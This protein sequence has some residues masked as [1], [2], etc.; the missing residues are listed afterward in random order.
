MK[1]SWEKLHEAPIRLGYR[2]LIRRVFRLPDGATADFEIKQESPTV[3]VVAVTVGG[4]ILLTRQFRPG[5]EATLLEL[6]GGAM[7]AGE[8]PLAAI[9]RELLEE[10]GYTGD[11]H[12]LGHSFHCAYSTRVSHSFVAIACS[13]VAEPNT[14]TCEV[15]EVVELPLDEFKEHVR[16]GQMTDAETAYRGLDFLRVL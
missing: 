12:Y 2:V 5:P 16:G 14:D 6:P 3:S 15:I 13:K 11:F 1:M 9:Q 4:G 10:T 8:T 7:D